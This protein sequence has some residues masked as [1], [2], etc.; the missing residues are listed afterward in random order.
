[1]PKLFITAIALLLSIVLADSS[2]AVTMEWHGTLESKLGAARR[3]KPS[4]AH[5]GLRGS[6]VATV[7][8]SGSGGL[9]NTLRLNGG[10]TGS[11]FNPVTD[12][13]TS[14]TIPIIGA[15]ATLGIGTISNI[16]NLPLVANNLTIQGFS[17]ICLFDPNCNARLDIP[18]NEG[19]NT[20]IGVGGILTVGGAG[21]IRISLE[22]GPWTIG[23]GSAVN[24]TDSGGFKNVTVT[25]FTHGAGSG[26]VS[27]AASGVIQLITPMQITT[28]GIAGN[29][30]LQSVFSI[31]TLHFVPEP[32]F[33]LLLG[34]GVVGLGILGR[35][36][37]GD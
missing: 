2:S 22:A 34:A 25:G 20:A 29:T 10:I 9:I 15:Q 1:M 28:S 19:P 18:Y 30:E 24:Q 16:Q 35:N 8:G 21:A 6:G 14:G 17:R 5:Q 31:L 11:D 4:G 33:L 36:R 12:P 7:N 32:G 3:F 27:A 26:A 23:S 37:L 13:D